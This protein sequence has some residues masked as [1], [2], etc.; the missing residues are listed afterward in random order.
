MNLA[1]GAGGLFAG[2]LYDAS[3]SLAGT[4]WVV[5]SLVLLLGI[6]WS[7]LARG[8]EGPARSSAPAAAIEETV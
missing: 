6:A 2:L 5:A 1:F 3:G 8:V 4:V 7:R